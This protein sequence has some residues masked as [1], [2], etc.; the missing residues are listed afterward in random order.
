MAS[1]M[2]LQRSVTPWKVSGQSR[3]VMMTMSSSHSDPVCVCMFRLHPRSVRSVRTSSWPP[4]T[5]QV[6]S[7]PPCS[8]VIGW[9][10]T[11]GHCLPANEMSLLCLSLPLPWLLCCWQEVLQVSKLWRLVPTSAPR[12][13]AQ[14]GESPPRGPRWNREFTGRCK[15]ETEHELYKETHKKQI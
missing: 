7:S 3:C 11:G 8:E 14:T 10:C 13:D 5:K 1:L 4:W 2:P 6:L 9:A 15:G 12:D